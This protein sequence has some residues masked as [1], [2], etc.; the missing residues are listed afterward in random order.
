SGRKSAGFGMTILFGHP[1]GNP[2]SHN[3]ALA[4]LEAELLECLCVAWMPSVTTMRVLNRVPPF[5]PLAQ[6]LGRRRFV[7]LANVPKVQGRIGEFCRLLIRASGLSGRDFS[8]QA[9]QWLVRTMAR[10]CHLS[11]VLA[12]HS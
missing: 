9:K 5:R 11:T 1:T 7:P 10:E 12:G 3:A 6:R 2:N 8:D 4:Y